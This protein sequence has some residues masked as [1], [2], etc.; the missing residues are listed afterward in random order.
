MLGGYI[1]D[2]TKGDWNRL[3]YLMIGVY[4]MGAL[5]WPFIDPVTPLEES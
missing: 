1:L 2:Y 3:L 5:C 4:V